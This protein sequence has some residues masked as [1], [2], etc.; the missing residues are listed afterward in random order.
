MSYRVF[1]APHADEQLDAILRVAVD[2]PQIAAAARAIDTRL[3]TNPS[4]LGESRHEKVRIAFVRP[5]GVEFEVLEDVK[6]VIVYE[7]WRTDLR[8]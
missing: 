7:V 3:V 8:H 2:Q 1:W 4:D 5:L 6:T